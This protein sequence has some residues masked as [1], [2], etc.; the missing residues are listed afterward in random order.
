MKLAW[1]IRRTGQSFS[2]AIK[3]AWA[4]LRIKK[5]PGGKSISFFYTKENGDERYAIA[6]NELAPPAPERQAEKP[7]KADSPLVIK[8][9]DMLA[10]GW[11]SFRADRLILC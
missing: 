7:K 10:S 11:R 1:A 4:S 5:Q 2:E 9:F 6:Q 3:R 8:Y